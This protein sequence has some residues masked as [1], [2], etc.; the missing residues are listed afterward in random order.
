MLNV[1]NAWSLDASDLVTIYMCFFYF[2]LTKM[3]V[4]VLVTDPKT[5]SALY[6]NLI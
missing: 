4:H 2:S 6:G 3:G 5:P 1:N